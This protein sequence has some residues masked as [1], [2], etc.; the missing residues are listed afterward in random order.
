LDADSLCAEIDGE[1]PEER[2]VQVTEAQ[3]PATSDARAALDHIYSPAALI[4]VRGEL[5]I[6]EDA[7]FCHR[8]Q[9]WRAA[10]SATIEAQ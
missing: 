1:T 3:D 2:A 8:W 6:P 4:T 10:G 9:R 5:G 7:E